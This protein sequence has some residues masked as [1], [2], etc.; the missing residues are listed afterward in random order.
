MKI[1]K[2]N[3]LWT[4]GLII[5][6]VLLVAIYA[7]KLI[8]PD[9]VVGVAEVDAV[10]K[11]GE[12]VDTHEWAFYLFG[13]IT[14]FATYYFYCCASCRKKYLGWRDVC[15]IS[16]VTIILFVVERFALQWYFVLN[17][18]SLIVCPALIC[19]L[20]KKTDI[21]YLYSTAICF[22]FENIAEV[23]SLM[24]R[25]L[26]FQISHPNIATYTILSIDGFIWLVLL[27]NYYNFKE[28][29]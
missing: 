27:Y 12:Y 17:I 3:N 28:I 9:F 26:E 21:K 14:S 6:A 24:I 1:K 22:A 23:G 16:L 29:K 10:V 5:C 11:F 8:V 4:M 7:L 15:I 18:T 13:F 19:S 25:D 2:F 20:D